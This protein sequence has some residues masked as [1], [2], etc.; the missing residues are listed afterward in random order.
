M[1]KKKEEGQAES[2]AQRPESRRAP[3]PTRAADAETVASAGQPRPAEIVMPPV[4]TLTS[5]PLDQQMHGNVASDTKPTDG[6]GRQRSP[7]HGSTMIQSVVDRHQ[8]SASLNK[9][10][11]QQTLESPLA[12]V[13]HGVTEA[14]ANAAASPQMRPRT[15]KKAPPLK[16]SPAPVKQRSRL[17][18]PEHVVSSAGK[19][20]GVHVFWEESAR[21]EESVDVLESEP[22]V[23]SSEAHPMHGVLVSEMYKAK[24]T[25]DA[26]QVS[27]HDEEPGMLD[28]INLGRS[29]RS[30]Q[31]SGL[32]V[33]LSLTRQAVEKL[34]QQITPLSRTME[35]LQVWHVA[36]ACFLNFCC[37]S[38]G[39]WRCDCKCRRTR[40]TCRRS[41]R[42]GGQRHPNGVNSLLMRF[43]HTLYWILL[44]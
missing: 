34:V 20:Q 16:G 31:R 3:K 35:Y 13:P 11:V 39:G 8:A 24:T 25:A 40:R 15:A 21:E 44:R 29:K 27:K 5:D 4:Q 41:Y 10:S 26:A 36:R 42:S 37:S 30:K 2:E 7:S 12:D 38:I 17:Q 32:H 43:R 33:N 28:G 14:V 18:P 6:T 23:Q 19:Q 9:P 22:S 1:L